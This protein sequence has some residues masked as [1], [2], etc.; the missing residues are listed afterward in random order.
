MFSETTVH[1]IDYLPDSTEYFLR[2]A[3]LGRRVWLDSGK[4]RSDYGRFDILSAAPRQR[5]FNPS[6]TEVENAVAGLLEEHSSAFFR[7]HELP[8]WGGAIG[9][10]NY[11]HNR[12]DYGLT[13]P[14]EAERESVVGIFDWALIVDHQLGR[15]NV[16]VLSSCD[17]A[18]A[19]TALD[20]LTFEGAPPARKYCV[21]DFQP[22][23]S[24]DR[25]LAK[26]KT[27]K[28]Y[29]NSGDTYQINFSQRFSG[30]FSGASDAA[31]L[32]LRAALPSPFSAYI[33]LG[34]DAILSFSPERF[35]AV[36]NGQACTQPIKGTAPRGKSKSDDARLAEHLI[37]SVKN[38]AENV[39]IVDLLRNDFSKCCLPFSVKTPSLFALES[40]ANVH[41]LVSTVTGQLDQKTSPLSLFK[42]CFPGGSIT[43][44]PK[45]RAMEIIYELEDNPRNIYCGSIFYLSCHGRLDSS[46]TIRTLLISED[47]VYCWGGGGIVS[48]SDAEEEYKETLQ[49]VGILIE[50][51]TTHSKNTH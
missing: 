42:H 20:A 47:H 16:V 14:L 40:F 2:L 17:P 50:H 7:D 11:E 30:T 46:I 12:K 28:D 41:H 1:P 29:I 8:F 33:D 49:K 6:E 36:D 24:Q 18:S 10:F 21:T 9:Y 25:Y 43:G 32:A 23:I 19:R 27:I 34:E 26:I 13:T 3:P 38:R 5:L 37:K 4:P 15:A 31:Y 44:A 35:I 48:D 45:K 51:L 39:M 22:D